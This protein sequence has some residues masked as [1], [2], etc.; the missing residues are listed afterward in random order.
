MSMAM[1]LITIGRRVRIIRTIRMM[2]VMRIMNVM[3]RMKLFR[4]MKPKRMYIM[5]ESCEQWER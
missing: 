4:A 3:N 5:R 1:N 2:Q